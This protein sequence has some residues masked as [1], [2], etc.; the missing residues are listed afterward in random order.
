VA[1]RLQA[2][3][4]TDEKSEKPLDK[5]VRRLKQI[6]AAFRQISLSFKGSAM[7]SNTE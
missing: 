1:T 2:E 4:E 3:L 6:S 7:L 5:E